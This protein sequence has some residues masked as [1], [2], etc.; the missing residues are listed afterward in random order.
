MLLVPGESPSL[1]SVPSPHT[2]PFRGERPGRVKP[3][4]CPQLMCHV[5][6]TVVPL[7]TAHGGALSGKPVPLFTL[8]YLRSLGE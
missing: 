5:N 1:A 8:N 3:L 4:L 6:E 2:P 7:V